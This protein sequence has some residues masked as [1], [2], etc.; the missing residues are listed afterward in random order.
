MQILVSQNERDRAVQAEKYE[1]LE[2]SQQDLIKTYEE[3]NLRL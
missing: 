2:R 3:E 1:N